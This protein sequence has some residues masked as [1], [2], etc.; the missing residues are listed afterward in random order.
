MAV[1]RLKL[2][3]AKHP[4]VGEQGIAPVAGGE[5]NTLISQVAKSGN[6]QAKDQDGL[7]LIHHAACR[8]DLPLLRKLHELGADMNQ[9]DNGNPP[10]RPIHY[11]IF[12]RQAEAEQV[13]RTFGVQAPP[14]IV[15]RV[16]QTLQGERE[17]HVLTIRL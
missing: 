13:L 14:S 3:R 10:W 8:G 16:A 2:S 15:N 7:A 12:H 5:L 6:L 9:F 4:H 11:A 17:R 1:D